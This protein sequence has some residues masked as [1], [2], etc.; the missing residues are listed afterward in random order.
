MKATQNP[1]PPGP[2]Q[3]WLLGTGVQQVKNPLRLLMRGHQRHGDLV[4][5]NLF[6]GPTL[7]VCHPEHAQHV[8]VENVRTYRPVGPENGRGG[9]LLGRGLFASRGDFWMRQ[10]RMVQPAFHRPRMGPMVAGMV[11]GIERTAE[12]WEPLARSGAQVDLLTEMRQLVISVLGESIFSRDA[13]AQSEPLR[14]GIDLITRDMHGPRDSLV[15]TVLGLLR[16]LPARRRRFMG[17]IQGLNS[18]LYALIAERRQAPDVGDDILGMLLGARDAQGEAMSD[19][20]VRDELVSLFVGGHEATAV[21]ATWCWYTLARNPEAQQRVRQELAEVLRGEPPSEATVQRLA[22][23]RAV[24]EETLR[25]HPP[26]WRVTRQAREEGRI[27]DWTVAPGTLVV[28]SPYI[29]HRHPSAWEQ[30][31]RFMPERFLAEQRE[32]R[33]QRQAYMP[34]GAGQRLCIGNHYT[35]LLITT[36]LATLMQRH[37]VRLSSERPVR[38][39]SGSTYRPRDGLMA[40]LQPVGSAS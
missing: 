35:L 32:R 1:L 25:L 31:E 26:A 18:A 14:G 23:T 13:Y 21:A 40:T 12:R 9:P 34:F 19:E 28:V 16:M 4:Y 3:H 8:L 38:A 27:G 30:P 29:L 36:A 7:L 24:V 15:T 20:Q 37:Q 5:F 11:R 2:K 39:M 6:E 10:R 17:A 22:Y 33:E